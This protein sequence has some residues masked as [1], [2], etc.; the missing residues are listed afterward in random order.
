VKPRYVT[1]TATVSAIRPQ[2][3]LLMPFC[4]LRIRAPPPGRPGR[5]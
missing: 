4:F 5:G 1:T 3:K 2:V